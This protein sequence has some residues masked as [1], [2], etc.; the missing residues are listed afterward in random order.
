MQAAVLFNDVFSCSNT[1][2]NN[3]FAKAAS[4]ISI[5]INFKQNVSSSPLL[6]EKDLFQIANA[7]KNI[8]MPPVIDFF[9]TSLKAGADSE[10]TPSKVLMVLVY[11]NA[12][13]AVYELTVN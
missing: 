1:N 9:I 5:N 4:D 3:G 10:N 11:A 6:L 12:R 13:T 8:C 7:H 2:V